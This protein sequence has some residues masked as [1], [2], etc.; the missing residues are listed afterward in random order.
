MLPM[1]NCNEDFA[2]KIGTNPREPQF[3]PDWDWFKMSQPLHL[4]DVRAHD[5]VRD[6]HVREVR[7][8]L[9][10]RRLI[11]ANVVFVGPAD[12]GDRGWVLV[13]TGL[14]GTRSLIIS[15][16]AARFGD[17]VRPAAILLTHGHFDHSG[18]LEDIAEHWD[19][20]V[21]AHELEHPYLTGRAAYPPGDSTVGGGLMASLAAL[22]PT[23]PVNVSERLH[24]FP[25]D[26]SVP[27]L[28]GWRWLH[29]PGHS[30][31]H[32]SFFRDHDRTM[33]VGDA[34]ATTNPESAY[35]TVTQSQ[36]LSGPPSYFTIDWVKA[37]DSVRSLA[38]LRPD[39]AICGH[40][41]AM[42][43]TEFADALQ[44]LA[45]R[46]DEM[47]VPKRGRYVKRAARVE[48]GSAYLM[49]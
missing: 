38:A 49:P 47:A 17:G 30:P 27:F 31:G 15:A 28:P 41:R 11:I 36:E 45:D 37:R 44:V 34:F 42:A 23:R 18:C 43:G 12:A 16:A 21:Y 7:D 10:Y 1:L 5:V 39:L 8:D 2:R 26:G 13:D 29:T 40:G 25:E 4:Q 32:V 20:P 22:Y 14:P 24:A 6:D 19:V 33:I 48:D 46:F 35:G 9:T 3:C